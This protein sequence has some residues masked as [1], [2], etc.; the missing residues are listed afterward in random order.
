MQLSDMEVEVYP[1]EDA[2][3]RLVNIKYIEDY[4]VVDTYIGK[5]E[6]CPEELYPTKLRNPYSIA[7]HGRDSAIEQFAAYFYHRYITDEEF[8]E[9]VHKCQGNVLGGWNYPSKCHGEIIIDL[10]LQ[11]DSSSNG[12]EVLAYINEELAKLDVQLLDI[13]GLK[14]QEE[15]ME[16][17]EE[18][19]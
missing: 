1:R 6:N 10:L 9:T 2:Q 17:I 19:I 14:Y 5:A 15:A 7:E 16:R 8:R 11:I 18:I 13:E 3:T 4:T 12:T